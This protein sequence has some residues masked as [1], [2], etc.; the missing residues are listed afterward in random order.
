MTN[1]LVV[2][3]P[4]AD[5]R[6]VSLMMLGS[7][8]YWPGLC[9]AIGRPNLVADPRF[10]TARDRAANSAACVAELDAI[11]SAQPLDHWR[12][13][14]A[15]QEGPWAVV[16]HVAEAVAD[17]QARANGYVQDVDYGDGRRLPMVGAPVQFDEVAPTLRP[18]PEHGAQTEEVLLEL[19]FDWEEISRLKAAGAVL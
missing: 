6:F 17:E 10:A 13:V 18:A 12:T 11:F 1:P 2:A 19:G 5:G 3:Y 8:R 4:T 15:G 16:A 9:Q 7:D 14:L